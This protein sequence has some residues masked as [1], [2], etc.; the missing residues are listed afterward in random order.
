MAWGDREEPRVMSDRDQAGLLDAERAEGVRASERVC[1]LH[2]RAMLIRGVEQ[3]LLGLFAEGKLFGTVHTCIGQEW[4]GLA[5]AE[6]L[7]DGDLIFTNHRGHGHF[8]AR[9]GDVEGLIAEVMGK[10]TG[11]CGGRGGS[12]H[13]C[14]GGVYSNGIQG[15]I[16][17]VS[18]G[19]AL[20]QQLRGTG[21]I[22]VVFIGDGTLGE[23][24]IYEAFNIASK[25]RLPLLIVLENNRYA[26]STPQ[27]QTL[28]G[29]IEAR[30]EAF[31]IVTDRADTWDPGTLL[32]AAARVIAAVRRGDGPRF[33]RID[34]DRLLAHSKGDDDRDPAEVRAYWDRDPLLAFAR[35]EPEQAEA[36]E[37]EARR[38]IDAAVARAEAAPYAE[39]PPADPP[40]PS[41]PPAWQPARFATQER[42]VVTIHDALRRN[43]ARDE[44]IVL[45]GE[46]IEGP[47]GGAFKV[48]KDLSRDFPGRVRN[49]PISES[50]I[51]GL[52]NG[53]ALCGLVPVCEIMF[54]DFLTL[55]AD[56]L[57][58]HAAKFRSMYNDQVELRL[59]VRTPMGGKRGY[60][61]THSQSLEK[62]FLGLPGTRMLAL[63][64]RDDPGALYDTLFATID[65]PTIVIENKL[66]YGLRVGA[67]APEGFVLERTDGPFPT[68]RI[69][70]EGTPDAT[71]L[72]Y[73]GMLADVEKAL[74]PL[75]DAHEIAC[76]VLCPTQLYPLDPRPIVESVERT[77]RLVVVE[78]GIGFAAFGAE[79]V[80]R[81]MELAPGA[82]R[83]LR[84][85]AAPE[86]PIPSCGPLEKA[87]LPGP[88]HVEAAVLE[89]CAS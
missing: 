27:E 36:F 9:T 41:E 60:G 8:L 58:N 19:M 69:R 4:T 29:E 55:A 68:T 6:A 44:R 48:T 3:R 52:G 56:Q 12:Q 37:A 85:M 75:F 11:V 59:V 62:H 73:G 53:L 1:A 21:R 15:G 76:E 7:I 57:I 17:P 43:M 81:I 84:R 88:A 61:P 77:G 28:A 32:S 20:A 26:Q 22:A 79:V 34:T 30:A 18:A 74:D 31:G 63:H 47:Y 50:A 70:P 23:G 16:V 87:L 2:A 54:G 89:L 64:H 86:H 49:M 71:I 83:R 78:E 33:L 39:P 72:C 46:D 14:A 80:A 65:R 35:E 10:Q 51:I 42:V 13:L 82:L 45:L 25:W 24:A 40:L 67:L 38:R 5:V 66:L